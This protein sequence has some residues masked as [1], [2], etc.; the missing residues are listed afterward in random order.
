M[1]K[2]GRK[3]AEAAELLR[4][5][6]FR[7]AVRGRYKGKFSGNSR[8]TLRDKSGKIVRVTTVGEALALRS[9]A[10]KPARPADRYRK[11]SKLAQKSRSAD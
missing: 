4:D 5:F 6:R 1:T 11:R 2:G 9:G 7:G 10:A 8:I 3:R